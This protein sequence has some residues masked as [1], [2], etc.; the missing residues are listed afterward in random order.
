MKSFKNALIYTED[1]RFAP[2]AFSVED[3][4]FTGVLAEPAEDAVDLRGAKVI[5]GLM[6]IH[7]H[8][9]SGADFSD[10]DY[11]G[12]VRM[13]RYYASVGV[14]S[15]AGTTLTLPYETIGAAL[16]TAVRL[17][18]EKPAGA[19]TLQGAYLEGP[20]FCAAK[21]GA[22]NADYLRLPDYEAFAELNAA[23][24]GLVS[25][26]AMA[27]ELEGA[28]EF[29]RK[30]SKDCTVSVGH[31]EADYD[32][33]VRAFEAGATQ[34]THLFNA[35]PSLHHRKPGAIVAGVE[36]PAVTA[37]IIGD[38]LHVHPAMVRLAFRLFGAERMVLVSDSLRC[39]GMPDGNYDLGGLPI[40]LSGGVARLTDGTLA[41]SATNL[42]ECMR[43]VVSF[44]IPEC[45]A[46]RAATYNPARQMGCL[47]RVGSIADGKC[48][49]FIV[50]GEDLTAKEIYLGGELL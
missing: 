3:G 10:G 32:T 34:L 17:R 25:V 5:P 19:A 36:N 18:K 40:T 13:A 29:I 47:D 4:R 31:T 7:S 12:L 41:G 38:G 1:F 22:Q 15:F 44:G 14:T 26:I 24:D 37:E 46:I 50:L 16:D 6:D 27:P 43:R 2:G 42:F 9:N 11:E 8:G 39:C 20:F 35:L 45:D 48:A 28:E 33:A 49:D 30:A 21:R 23:S